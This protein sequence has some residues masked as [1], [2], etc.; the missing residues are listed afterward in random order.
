MGLDKRLIDKNEKQKLKDMNI[1]TEG[2]DVDNL[3]GMPYP[4]LQRQFSLVPLTEHLSK[5]SRLTNIG[6]TRCCNCTS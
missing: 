1:D 6:I 3:I 4:A 5:E 2:G